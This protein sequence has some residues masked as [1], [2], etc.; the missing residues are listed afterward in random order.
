MALSRTDE[1]DLLTGLH[2]HLLDAQDPWRLFLER[3]RARLDA[4]LARIAFRVDGEGAWLP[5]GESRV[6]RPDDGGALDPP[7]PPFANLR[8]GRVYA[9]AE[10]GEDAALYARHLRVGT[11]GDGDL[12]LSVWDAGQDFRAGDSALLSAL[13]PHLSLALATRRG[14]EWERRRVVVAATLLGGLDFGWLLLDGEGRLLDHDATV[15]GLLEQ[16]HALARAADGRLRLPYPAAEGLLQKLLAR[17]DRVGT[18]PTAEWIEIAPRPTQI[19]FLSAAG[20]PVQQSLPAVALIGVVRPVV[21]RQEVP[22]G[23]IADLFS[24]S[25]KEAALASQI[26]AGVPI[27]EAAEVLGLTLETARNYSKRLYAKTSSR[28]QADL[29]SVIHAGVTALPIR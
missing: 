1:R 22:P 5:A 23:P 3:L 24:L 8:P 26:A 11:L 21:P 2:A 18:G 19:R 28:G 20:L 4:G 9:G 25:G 7:A 10:L 16:G 6:R 17:P 27:A 15:G 14:I 12:V 13:V 29:A